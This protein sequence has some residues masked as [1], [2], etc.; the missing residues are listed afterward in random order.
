[1]VRTRWTFAA[2]LMIGLAWCV[3]AEEVSR[4]A[5]AFLNAI[6]ASREQK[7]GR[8]DE[9]T[10]AFGPAIRAVAGIPFDLRAEG[11]ALWAGERLRFEP[12]KF[13]YGGEKGIASSLHPDMGYLA[14]YAVQDVYLLHGTTD[15]LPGRVVGRIVFEYEDGSTAGED[16]V[17]GENIGSPTTPAQW[18]EPVT[19]GFCV[20][21][22]MNPM[23]YKDMQFETGKGHAL[24]SLTVSMS[25]TGLVYRLAA[26]TCRLGRQRVHE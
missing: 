11:I 10:R 23:P 26:I 15:G 25:T 21:T 12:D 5:C 8:A 16:F 2:V 17:L 9:S 24:K 1:M 14:L 13:V 6:Q 4:D 18:A 22:V 3:R 19:N 20:T 7:V